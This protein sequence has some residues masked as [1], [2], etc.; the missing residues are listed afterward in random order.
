MYI[1]DAVLAGDRVKRVI[2]PRYDM[3]VENMLQIRDTY[4]GKPI[5][6][7]CAAFRF[8]YLQGTKAAIKGEITRCK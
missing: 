2:N 6:C 8:G 7:I 4:N 3:S 1:K 5:D